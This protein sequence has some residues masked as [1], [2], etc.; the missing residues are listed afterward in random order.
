MSF[1]EG[2]PSLFGRGVVLLLCAEGTFTRECSTHAR[3]AAAIDVIAFHEKIT[4]E[5]ITKCY[6]INVQD[7]WSSSPVGVRLS[8][9]QLEFLKTPSALSLFHA[10]KYSSAREE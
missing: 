7:I 2:F 1:L 4:P 8:H 5:V 9:A 10:A 3:V 6:L